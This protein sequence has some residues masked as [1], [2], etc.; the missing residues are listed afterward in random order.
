MLPYAL[1]CPLQ[2]S[3]VRQSTD[4]A[5]LGAYRSLS[6]Q[7]LLAR[8]G[9]LANGEHEALLAGLPAGTFHVPRA[10]RLGRNPRRL[11]ASRP[12]DPGSAEMRCLPRTRRRLRLLKEFA[13]ADVT[14]ATRCKF[15]GSLPSAL[16]RSIRTACELPARAGL[17][18][19]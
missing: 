16:T 10:I 4:E 7:P 6:G 8:E 3:K 9:R 14:I 17:C 12:N 5:Y 11:T 1:P 15:V 13:A 2:A 18:C 19:G